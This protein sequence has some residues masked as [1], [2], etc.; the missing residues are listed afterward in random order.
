MNSGGNTL[1]AWVAL[2]TEEK[3]ATSTIDEARRSSQLPDGR[4]KKYTTIGLVNPWHTK[5]SAMINSK[6]CRGIA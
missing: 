1:E 4:Q 5:K 2:E 3:R 6:L